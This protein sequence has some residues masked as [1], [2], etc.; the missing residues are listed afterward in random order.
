LETTSRNQPKTSN[1]IFGRSAWFRNLIQPTVGCALAY[2]DWSQQEFGIAAALSQDPAMISAYESGDPYLAFGK[3]AGAIPECGTKQTHALQRERFKQCALAVLYGG[4]PAL[5]ATRTGLS[6]FEAK[7]LICA[8][9]KSYPLFWEWIGSAVDLVKL[10]GVLYTVFGWRYHHG[11]KTKH[12]TI[13]NFPMQANGAEMMRLAACELTENGINVCAPV[14]DAFLIEAKESN[15]ESTVKLAQKIMADASRVVLG[16]KL[17][18]RSDVKTI[19]FPARYA[20]ERGD[21]MWR[22]VLA[23][24]DEL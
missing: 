20:D 2:V 21:S 9:K 11:P 3:Q 10:G 7:E 19:R 1:F 15:L 17:V 18:L 6:L 16:S 13:L 23:L 8:H 14:H 22:T 4:G 12:G 5:I 24:L